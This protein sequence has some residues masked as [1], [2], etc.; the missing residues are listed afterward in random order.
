MPNEVSVPVNGRR[1]TYKVMIREAELPCKESPLR[2]QP[3]KEIKRDII[4]DNQEAL[5]GKSTPDS[6]KATVKVSNGFKF[7]FKFLQFLTN[8]TMPFIIR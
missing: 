3:F 1:D 7:N 5:I 4:I 6:S 2:I 8:I